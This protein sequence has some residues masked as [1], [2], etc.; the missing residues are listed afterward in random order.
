MLLSSRKHRVEAEAKGRTEA[1]EILDKRSFDI[2]LLDLTLQDGSGLDLLPEL[3]QRDVSVLIY[4]MHEDSSLITRAFRCGALGY[5]SK[6]EDTDILLEA[7]DIVAQGKRFLSPC[8]LH[9]LED[10]SLDDQNLEGM[11]SDR[12]KQIFTM[13]GHGYGSKEI[14][15]KLE[16]SRRTVETYCVRMVRKMDFAERSELRKYAISKMN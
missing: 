14:A 7:I 6:Q 9:C 15:E 3:E 1:L 5:V 12:E 11:L 16:L 10:K 8:A 13:M 2:A 4:T